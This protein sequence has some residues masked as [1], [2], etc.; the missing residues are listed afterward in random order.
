MLQVQ[1]YLKSGK[2]LDDLNRELAINVTR[3]ESLPLVILNYD[4]LD[5]PKTD[6]LVRECRSLVLN[7]ENYDLVARSFHRFFNWGEVQDEMPLFQW[8]GA[9]VQEK[10]DGSLLTFYRWD[11][12]WRV[13]TRGSFA[14]GPMFNPWQAEFHNMPLDFTWFD[15]ILRALNVTSLDELNLDPGLTYACELCSV[16]NKV[17]RDYPSPSVYQLAN[18]S[19]HAEVP[20]RP[21]VAFKQLAVYPLKTAAEVNQYVNSHPESSFEGCV[22]RDVDYRRWKI[23]NLR[24][25]AL[26]KLKGNNGENLYLPKNLVPIIL[27]GEDWEVLQ[28]Y[29]EVTKCYYSFKA[30]VEE[31]YTELLSVWKEY[32]QIESQKEFALAIQGKTPFTGILFNCRK[33]GGKEGELRQLWKQ[34]ADGIVKTLFKKV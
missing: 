20:L 11:G 26:S 21:H 12:H 24:W 3:H 32:Y 34:N 23:K 18:F 33:A 7:S 6:N 5:S 29:P 17:V 22:V 10:V 15:A 9:T 2:T 19:G 31:A 13:N 30:K 14:G 25:C 8:D 27:S 16:W 28:P 4:Q 1:T